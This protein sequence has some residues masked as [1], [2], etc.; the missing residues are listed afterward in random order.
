MFFKSNTDAG[1]IAP[2]NVCPGIT[3]AYGCQIQSTDQKTTEKV[4]SD[5]NKASVRTPG[6]SLT[7]G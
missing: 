7:T 1:V 4:A 2:N 6:L 5:E 3:C